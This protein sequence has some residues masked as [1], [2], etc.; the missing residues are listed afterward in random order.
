MIYPRLKCALTPVRLLSTALLGLS[1]HAAPGML[2]A[3][4]APSGASTSPSKLAPALSKKTPPFD[5]Q[6]F[7]LALMAEFDA[8][9][10]RWDQAFQSY[11]SLALRNPLPEH[12]DKAVDMALKGRSALNAVHGAKTWVKAHPKSIEAHDRLVMILIATDKVD[13]LKDPLIQLLELT[14]PAQRAQAIDRLSNSLRR[15]N[16]K[17]QV[18][19]LAQVV[20]S[21]Y[22]SQAETSA[23]AKRTMAWL[24]LRDGR[25]EP[26]L[27]LAR[28]LI[29]QGDLNADTGM[30][31]VSL[32][33]RKLPGAEAM[34][35]AL[36]DQRNLPH[37]H[38]AYVQWLIRQQQHPLALERLDALTKVSPELETAWLIKG[39]LEF[40]SNRFE[41][42]RVSLEKYL[43]LARQAS[44]SV[45]SI[46]QAQ[47]MLAQMA[48][49]DK[50]L[51]QADALL[52][53]INDP[54]LI[55]EVHQQRARIR[56]DLHGVPAALAWVESIPSNG[57]DDERKKLVLKAQLL[58]TQQAHGQVIEVLKK[59]LS[60]QPD[61]TDLM[62]E[63]A[64]VSE[65]AGFWDEFERLLRR[66]IELKPDAAHAYNALGYSFADRNIRLPEAK[67][68]IE[69]AVKLSPDD[70]YILDSLAWVEYRLGNTQLALDL[71]RKA[72]A[73][74]ADP[75]IAAHLGEVLWRI[76]QP[77]QARQVWAD[78]LKLNPDNLVLKSTMDRFTRQ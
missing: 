28:E 58:K 21:P 32:T 37:V 29:A 54:S 59:A 66:V 38:L 61:D 43:S 53:Q 78:S 12:F 25:A 72:F 27:N 10:G 33:D 1:L 26:A 55:W 70:A 52:A 14:P 63:L 67:A 45:R 64:M 35:R 71:L 2:Q 24:E 46:A 65:K 20:L 76:G 75:E 49:Q 17:T 30:L 31:L 22:L 69:K 73:K 15:S 4:T 36:L 7:H 5:A 41:S 74:Q 44:D 23:I 11:L 62:Y 56:S 3:Q 18:R 57:K 8:A 6:G 39:G 48:I 34:L 60:L 42:S 68:L 40:E 47:L 9:A 19:Q 16:Q 13:E 51:E 50:R 77:D